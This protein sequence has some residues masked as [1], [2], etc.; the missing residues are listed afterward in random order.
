MLG[1]TGGTTGISKGAI[2]T[3]RNLVAQAAITWGW[4][5]TAEPGK[6]IFMGALPLFH[7]FGMTCVLNASVHIG[8]AMILM[9][10]PRE[11]H[12]V[13]TAV[14]KYHPTFFPG[15]PTLYA[16]INN[17]PEAKKYDLSS[18]KSCLSGGAPLPVEVI[19]AFG[20]WFQVVNMAEKVHRVRRRRQYMHD[21]STPQPGGLDSVAGTVHSPAGPIRV[22][23]TRDGGRTKVSLSTPG[24]VEPALVTAAGAR[25]DGLPANTRREP[26]PVPGTARWKLPPLEKQWHFTL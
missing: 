22:D 10:N 15:V 11:L 12:A 4:F 7:S 21:S 23:C 13:L 2:L 25:V 9:P 24:S 16:A 19:R 17:S 8:A 26:G 14:H 5:P 18:I 3:H 20:A 1:Y 6:E